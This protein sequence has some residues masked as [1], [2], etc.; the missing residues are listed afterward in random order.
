MR[1]FRRSFRIFFSNI[2]DHLGVLLPIL[3]SFIRPCCAQDLSS[4]STIVSI[5][6]LFT[7][8]T[9]S[10]RYLF[11]FMLFTSTVSTILYSALQTWPTHLHLLQIK[12]HFLFC[13]FALAV[14][15]YQLCLLR[16]VCIKI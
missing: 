11:L 15:L 9:Q 7:T 13:T 16:N 8:T 6:S 10:T 3:I 4:Y 12:L 14:R 2:V 1:L 5:L